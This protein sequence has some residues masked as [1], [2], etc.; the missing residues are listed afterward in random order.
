MRLIGRSCVTYSTWRGP[1]TS[2]ARQ[3]EIRSPFR[4]VYLQEMVGQ[5]LISQEGN[6]IRKWA[7][8]DRCFPASD[9]LCFVGIHA[10]ENLSQCLVIKL[11][12]FDMCPELGR[13]LI[14]I[15][16]RLEQSIGTLVLFLDTDSELG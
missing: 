14:L 6:L 8:R 2:H 7:D 13:Y 4:I 1:G 16:D 9:L 11:S 15:L 10:E 5:Y 3:R 12:I